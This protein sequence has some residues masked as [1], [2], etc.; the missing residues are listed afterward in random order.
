[1]WADDQ[2]RLVGFAYVNCYQN[3]VDVFDATWFSPEIETKLVAWVVA[4]QQKRNLANSSMLLARSMYEEIPELYIPEGF[5]IRPLSGEAELEAYVVL[6]RAAF[7]SENTTIEHRQA[8]LLAPDYIPELDLVAVAPG[9]K[10]A[11]LCVCQIFPDDTPRAGGMKEGW[12]DP[13][14][15]YPAYLRQGLA[16]LYCIIVSLQKTCNKP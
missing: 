13:V 4:A 2:Q 5:V 10:L 3:L 12:T 1:L 7:G 16:R 6:H 14:A 15:T 8:I 11:A 9:E